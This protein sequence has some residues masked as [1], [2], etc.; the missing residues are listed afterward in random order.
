MIKYILI[1]LIIFIAVN[2]NAYSIDFSKDISHI[3][4][5]RKNKIIK[6]EQ[7]NNIS[8]D[9]IMVSLKDNIKN[10]FKTAQ[11]LAKIVDGEIIGRIP[12]MNSWQIRVNVNSEEEIYKLVAILEKKD[13]VDFCFIDIEINGEE[14]PPL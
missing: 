8:I 13:E 10:E 5:P 12:L 14:P 9:Y 6:N 1:I 2:T 4:E 11:K 3:E 7:G